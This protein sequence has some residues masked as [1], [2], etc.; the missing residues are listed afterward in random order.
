MIICSHIFRTDSCGL[1]AQGGSA[2]F[3]LRAAVSA[4]PWTV[5]K[6]LRGPRRSLPPGQL[7]AANRLGRIP[8]AASGS[9][10]SPFCK[11]ACSRE[12]TK[13]WENIGDHDQRTVEAADIARVLWLTRA[14]IWSTLS[15]P[16]QDQVA[17]WLLQVNSVVTRESNW[18]I[19]SGRR[20][21]RSGS[22]R[23]RM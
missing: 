9:I 12:R 2:S 17:N 5:F 7:P 19:F 15:K 4:R 20:Q 18:L 3:I 22:V 8:W 21:F 16:K 14:Q 23:L 13:L 11:K 6:A 10:S 1:R